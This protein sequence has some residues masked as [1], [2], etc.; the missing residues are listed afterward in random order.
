MD[1]GINAVERVGG[2]L[3][4]A[5]DA[6][7]DQLHAIELARERLLQGRLRLAHIAHRNEG[8]RLAACFAAGAA[9]AAGLRAFIGARR[10][11]LTFAFEDGP[12]QQLGVPLRPASL[13]VLRFSDGT[14]VQL[15]RDAQARVATVDMH[16]ARVLLD[17]GTAHVSVVHHP[18]ARWAFEAGP[19][20]ITVTGT[21]FDLTW[22]SQ[23]EVL[24]LSMING[25][26][27]IIGCTITGMDAKGGDLV[28]LRCVQDRPE[29]VMRQEGS[30]AQSANA[31]TDPAIAQLRS[32]GA[33]ASAIAA[34]RAGSDAPGDLAASGIA[35][36]GL[37]DA[38]SSWQDLAQSARYH[39]AYEKIASEFDQECERCSG[40][41]LLRL[42]DVAL[43]CGHADRARHAL[44][45]LRARFAGT[46]LGST[47]AF[48]LGTIAFDH[49]GSLGD[50]ARWF[51]LYLQEQP[52]GALA[53]EAHGRLMEIDQ[54][55]GA[56]MRARERAQAYLKS[57]PNGPHAPLARSLVG[58]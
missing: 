15:E 19:F 5:Q 34:G 44:E 24:R 40:S 8:L 32:P 17:R 31:A 14:R 36:A 43:L 58:E 6:A 45:R 1:Q 26:V 37:A 3:A 7:L 33:A 46:S 2:V 10:S 47:A 9:V 52:S 30:P 39:D 21:Q 13:G 27:K 50:A 35:D 54:R 4:G 29:F 41:D 56:V 23:S 51:E 20:E 18:I 49:Q 42:S 16:G 48:R 55:T 25:S 22:D 57:W 11:P 53:R 38:S 28:A 12:S